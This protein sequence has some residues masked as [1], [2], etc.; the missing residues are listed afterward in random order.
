MEACSRVSE[1]GWHTTCVEP[2]RLLISEDDSERTLGTS[3][4]VHGLIEQSGAGSGQYAGRPTCARA[5]AGARAA[6]AQMATNVLIP[7]TDTPNHPRKRARDSM[8]RRAPEA[9]VR[10]S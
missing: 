7:R 1:S 2:G 6:S 8:R 10:R 5:V 9:A 4:P 3:P